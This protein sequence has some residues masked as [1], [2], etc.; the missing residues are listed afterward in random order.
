MSLFCLTLNEEE[1]EKIVEYLLNENKE[2]KISWK[3]FSKCIRLMLKNESSKLFPQSLLSNSLDFP[4]FSQQ[5]HWGVELIS[6][7]TLQMILKDFYEISQKNRF[8]LKFIR[9]VNIDNLHDDSL[10]ISNAFKETIN[11]F[12]T[13]EYLE[14]VEGIESFSDFL[15]QMKRSSNII[16][17]INNCCES[18]WNNGMMVVDAIYFQLM[19]SNE[20]RI[21]LNIFSQI[22]P[23]VIEYLF[24]Y[25]CGNINKI[26]NNF[27]VRSMRKDL[28][29][30]RFHLNI[31]RRMQVDEMLSL[32]FRLLI[33]FISHPLHYV[34]WTKCVRCLE[35]LKLQK[36]FDDVHQS[37]FLQ[38]I[39]QFNSQRFQLEKEKMMKLA[40]RRKEEEEKKRNQLNRLNEIHENYRRK[41][42]E[43][44]NDLKIDRKL[45]NEKEYHVKKKEIIEEIRKKYDEL[46]EEQQR[47][48]ERI[49][50]KLK[51]Y[52]STDHPV[53][54][55]MSIDYS[56]L[57][58]SVDKKLDEMNEKVNNIDEEINKINDQLNTNQIIDIN[59]IDISMEN[60]NTN[61]NSKMENAQ[62]VSPGTKIL[63]KGLSQNLNS[64]EVLSQN[65]NSSEVLSGITNSSEVF[66][67]NENSTTIILS[68]NENSSKILSENHNL[69]RREEEEI[70][71][72]STLFRLNRYYDAFD[73]KS[74][75][76]AD[77]VNVEK[78]LKMIDNLDTDDEKMN[79]QSTKEVDKMIHNIQ[80]LIRIHARYV[81]KST[82]RLAWFDFNGNMGIKTFINYLHQFYFLS[83]GN[84]N[85][86][87]NE[88]I[89]RPSISYQ[90]FV[91]LTN[92]WNRCI[93]SESMYGLFSLKRINVND[94]RI[95]DN[96]K[97]ECS[98]QNDSLNYIFSK[99]LL[100]D[101]EKLFEFFF[102]LQYVHW[103]IN[104]SFIILKTKQYQSIYST[105]KQLFLVRYRM[106]RF[107]ST[108][109][110]YIQLHV[111]KRFIQ[112]IHKLA[113]HSKGIETFRQQHAIDIEKMLIR[114]FLTNKL[115]ILNQQLNVVFDIIIQFTTLILRKEFIVHLNQHWNRFNSAVSDFY[116][117]LLSISHMIHKPSINFLLHLLDYS[118]VFENDLL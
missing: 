52:Y 86:L 63:S 116:Q 42:I 13:H 57:I 37:N 83:N 100:D 69:N 60:D 96:V 118:S 1:Y 26:S 87:I 23:F 54:Q 82:F 108:I 64:S 47:K 101:Y 113:I 112:S 27:L 94:V 75:K 110:T 14:M 12:L 68:G 89:F 85:S 72:Y 28:E 114:S 49:N 3:Q 51:R 73:D 15:H 111:K 76:Y 10:I 43:K 105:S 104:E 19:N 39:S 35:M 17:S 95:V 98:I 70:D 11:R 77:I 79:F 66:S 109:I 9:N 81:E 31:N 106:Q 97:M 38:Q 80:S 74:I 16:H 34:Q 22:F 102:K 90:K 18:I 78:D 53:Q 30:I 44:E 61:K 21:W 91:S 99:E 4:Q 20:N 107:I 41:L 117:T 33:R 62:N 25:C 36:D 56:Y 6:N 40:I 29:N 67:A 32:D 84:I 24:R 65:L 71:N 92:A 8:I 59:Q 50:W 55:E 7:E 115:K 93:D 88:S 58:N 45:L 5:I 48:L 46:F 2:Q 103:C